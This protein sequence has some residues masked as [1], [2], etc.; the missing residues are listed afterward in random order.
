MQDMIIA[1][2]AMGALAIVLAF[3]FIYR[4]KLSPAGSDRMVEIS[5][6]IREG[7]MAF[8]FREYKILFVYCAVLFAILFMS[9]LGLATASSFL[10]GAFLSLTAGYLGMKAATLANVRTSEAARSKGRGVA[11]MAAF[12]GGAVMGLCVAGLGLLGLGVS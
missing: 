7:A 2:P 4:I 11:L 12:D 10:L 8:L 9:A 5:G 1:A 3:I 6:F